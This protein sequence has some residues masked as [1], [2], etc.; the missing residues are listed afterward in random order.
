MAESPHGRIVALLALV[1]GAL[2]ALAGALLVGADRIRA[3]L[4]VGASAALLVAVGARQWQY[5]VDGNVNWTDWSVTLAVST[6]GWLVYLFALRAFVSHPATLDP[7]PRPLRL[8]LM[9]CCAY[10]CLGLVFAGRHRDFPV[11]LFLP[12][13][14]AFVIT[15]LAHPLARGTALRSSSANEEVLLAVWLVVAGVAIPLLER[16]QNMRALGWGLSSALLGLAILAPLALQARKR[17]GAAEHA[18]AGPR[19]VVQHH[20]PGA[21]R[22]G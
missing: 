3:G 14:L 7:I 11:W 10:V 4:A 17:K 13:V 15:A 20:A 16:M 9:L 12:G 1:A 5:L 21:D 18:D 2:G 22:E 8:L 6:A 19:E